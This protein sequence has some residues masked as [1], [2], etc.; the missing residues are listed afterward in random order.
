MKNLFDNPLLLLVLMFF[1]VVFFGAKQFPDAARSLGR[2]MRLFKTEVKE[3]K[4]GDKDRHHDASPLDSRVVDSQR[5][6]QGAGTS[7][8]QR[9]NA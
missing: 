7:N 3:M 5:A 6:E 2:S 1:I 8:G 4:E 9:R